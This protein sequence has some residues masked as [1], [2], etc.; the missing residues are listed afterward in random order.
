MDARVRRK[1]DM[2]ARALEFGH[3]HPLDSPGYTATMVR[4]EERLGRAD[5][6]AT[7]QRDGILAVRAA[8]LHKRELMGKARRAHLA[9]LARIADVA[10]SEL[11][12]LPQKF[13]LKPGKGSYRAFRTAA[14]RVSRHLGDR[15]PQVR[16]ALALLAEACADAQQ[17]E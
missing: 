6:L 4:L 14:G 2:G 9:H 7:Q 16:E 11:P 17:Q 1:L 13:L 15:E 3:A 8:T 10:G 5:M 12:E